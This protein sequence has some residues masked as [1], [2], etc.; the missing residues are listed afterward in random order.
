LSFFLFSSTYTMI[1]HNSDFIQRAILGK[2]I[3][4]IPFTSMHVEAK[5][6]KYFGRFRCFLKK[7]CDE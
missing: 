1:I 6:T 7:N 5:D 4:K 3:F 2:H